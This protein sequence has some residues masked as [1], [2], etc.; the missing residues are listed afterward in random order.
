MTSKKKKKKERSGYQK[1]CGHEVT[2]FFSLQQIGVTVFELYL[3]H[4]IINWYKHTSMV[5]DGVL[6]ANIQFIA[7]KLSCINIFYLRHFSLFIF[8]VDKILIS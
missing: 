2:F 5:H 4:E 8:I 6:I 3:K 1:L 7:F